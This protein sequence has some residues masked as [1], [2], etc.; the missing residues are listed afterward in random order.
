M[1]DVR[2]SLVKDFVRLVK[3]IQPR[4]F[5]FENVKGLTLGEHKIFLSELIEE[6][7]NIGYHVRLPWRVL[8]A[9]NYGVPQNRERLILMGSRAKEE[10]PDYPA[11]YNQSPTKSKSKKINNGFNRTIGTW[12]NVQGRT[13]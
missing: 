2:N 9:S 12:A 3:E 8:N 6:F 1:D 10:L 4:F 13:G 11:I 7:K 5:V